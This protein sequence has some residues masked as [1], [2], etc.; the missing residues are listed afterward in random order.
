MELTLKTLKPIWVAL[1]KL[2]LPI[3]VSIILFGYNYIIVPD[4]EKKVHANSLKELKNSGVLDSI[5]KDVALELSRTDLRSVLSKETGIPEW[6]IPRE[7]ATAMFW[8]D[9]AVKYYPIVFYKIKQS[10]VFY[11][12]NEGLYYIDDNNVKNK[13]K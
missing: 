8:S 5:K 10:N 6:K 9:S 2:S 4:I 11:D 7:I 1:N 13:I 3:V 12:K